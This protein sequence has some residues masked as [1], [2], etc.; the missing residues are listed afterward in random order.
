MIE[1]GTSGYDHPQ[2][3]NLIKVCSNATKCVYIV[4]TTTKIPCHN[5]SHLI[6]PDDLNLHYSLEY[7]FLGQLLFETN[8]EHV[9]CL[10]QKHSSQMF[11]LTT[12]ILLLLMKMLPRIPMPSMNEEKKE[13]VRIVKT[14]QP[15]FKEW[16]SLN[17]QLLNL[18]IRSAKKHVLGMK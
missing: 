16:K 1:K 11:Y 5:L 2:N 4:D 9:P 18:A 12:K 7:Q 13:I 8:V 3:N 6:V 14:R 10:Q 17:I 15:S